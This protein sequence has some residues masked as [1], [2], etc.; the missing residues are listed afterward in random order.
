MD[1]LLDPLIE[2]VT[3]MWAARLGKTTILENRLGYRLDRDQGNILNV[4]PTDKKAKRWS[5]IH[6]GPLIRDNAAIRA[7]V[8]DQ[9]T[10]TKGN[11]ILY[12]EYQGGIIVIAGAN[13][14]SSLSTW[15]MEEI[16]FDEVDEYPASAG[17]AGDPI[18]LAKQRAAN[19]PGHKF[20][21]TSTPTIKGLSRIDSLWDMS[22][23]RLC[24]VPCPICR[25]YQILIFGPRSMFSYLSTGMLKFDR[26][27]LSWIYYECANCKQ[28][29][30]ER[31]K[32]EM[33]QQC[34]W[35]K[36]NPLIKNHAGFQLNR[37]YSPWSS[38]KSIAQEFLK[39]EKR[40][41]RLKVVVTTVFGEPYVENINY[42]FAGDTLMSR[43]EAYTK[44]PMG[45]IFMTV[46]LD[47]N[48]DRLT[49]VVRG[50][51]LND[52]SWFVDQYVAPGSPAKKM[53]WDLADAFIFKPREYENGYKSKFGM[54]GGI[55]AVG[56]DTGGHFTQE[57]YLY[58][59]RQK[60]S[61]FF[62]IKGIGGFGKSFIKQSR[63]KKVRAPLVLVG[64]D[65]GKQLIYER[66]N[67][68][69]NVAGS[70]PGYMHFNFDCDQ[71]Y[72]DELTSE[73][74]KIK[75][76]KGFPTQEWVLPEGKQNERL[77]C[78][79]YALAAYSL[80]KVNMERLGKQLEE[81]MKIF[82]AI[83]TKPQATPTESS[84]TEQKTFTSNRPKKVMRRMRLNLKRRW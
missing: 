55:L 29:I 59:Q 48:D 17:T 13:T 11:E 63:N 18:E 58:V 46:G 14:P 33:V 53:T 52:E 6:L 56:V 42:Q 26:E 15:S 22:D 49:V 7:K 82:A 36:Q 31:Y 38:W 54:L 24:Y 83:K 69:K 40:P 68:Q 62:G 66:L 8:N 67:I 28:P 79:N 75:R 61:R 44:I 80:L 19:F 34:E 73:K 37:L 60:G 21:Y 4:L 23:K 10:R 81:K 65:A 74:P 1:V 50:W 70:T 30:A 5:K 57:A 35:R 45:V 77:D 72:F 76:V 78:E 25:A 20:T 43:R 64:V 16:F 51:G 9:L 39:A 3:L 41:E 2:E 71:N 32:N 84:Q 27:N 47:V 12:K